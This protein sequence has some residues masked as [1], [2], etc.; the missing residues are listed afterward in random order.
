[1]QELFIKLADSK[2][3][4]KVGN[5]AAYARATAINLAFDWRRKETRLKT[6]SDEYV[7]AV[8]EDKGAL[9]RLIENEQLQATLE[10]ADRLSKLQRQ[11]FIMRYIEQYS[12]EQIAQEV[13]KTAHH[14]RALASRALSRV[15][16]ICSKIQ[17]PAGDMKGGDHVA[18]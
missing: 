7:E 5:L 16:E 8:S 3:L 9:T 10:A 2:N 15:R 1:M 18:N 14:V 11:V 6:C 4:S 12:F 17:V 13:G